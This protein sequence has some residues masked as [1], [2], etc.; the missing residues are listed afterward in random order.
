MASRVSMMTKKGLAHPPKWLPQNI[1]YEVIMGSVAY[2][3][4]SDTSDMDVYGFAIPPKECVFPHLSGE[5]QGFGRQK[6]R[7]EQYQEHHLMDKDSNKEY[8]FSIYSIVKALREHRSWMV[9][10]DEQYGF[11]FDFLSQH[12]MLC[13]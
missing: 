11:T 3:V 2:G 12:L 13:I 9:E 7:F 8:D 6:K 10:T 4:S 1:H 5:I